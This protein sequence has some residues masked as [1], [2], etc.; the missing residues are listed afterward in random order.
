[1]NS[2][3]AIFARLNSQASIKSRLDTHNNKPAI[4]NDRAPDAFV[5]GAKA[6]IVIAASTRDEPDDTFTEFGREVVQDVRIYAKDGGS[7]A[8][9]DQLAR[10]IRELFHARPSE[11]TVDG[12]SCSLATA[13][14]PVAAPTTDPSLIGR[15]VSLRLLLQKDT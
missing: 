13:T 7:T 8:V 2:T 12:G 5:F 4:F 3:A 9:I 10:D 6:A 11:L 14:G 15:R 1:M